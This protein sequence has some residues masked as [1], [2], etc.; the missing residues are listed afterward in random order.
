MKIF[1]NTYILLGAIFLSAA[2]IAQT[3]ELSLEDCFEL[4]NKN[5]KQ[6]VIQLSNQ[7]RSE[8]NY[9]FGKFGF[10]PTISANPNYNISFGRKLDPFTNTFGNNTIYSNSFSLMSQLTLFQSFRYF[11][12]NQFNETALKNTSLDIER[13]QDRNRNVVLEKCIAIWKLELKIEQQK[14]II[15]NTHQFKLRQAELVTEGRI[16]AL[17]TLQTAINGKTQSIELLNLTRD[18]AYE[19]INLNYYL[20]LPLMQETKLKSFRSD[21][22]KELLTPEE[23]YELQNIQNNLVLAEIQ[24][25][26]DKTQY[27]PSLSAFGNVGTGYSTNNKDYTSPSAP[28]IQYNQQIAN[29]MYQSIGFS[30]NIPILNKGE[31]FRRQKL[32]IISQAEQQQ[33]IELK[34]EEI[35]KKRMEIQLQKSALQ[36]SIILQKEILTNK[37]TIYKMSQLLYFE[38]KIRLNELEE[39]ETDYHTFSQMIQDLDLELIKL[40]M[41][42][43]N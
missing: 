27:Y 38:G 14:K 8:I 30:L 43:F 5:E 28:V 18:L 3:H 36:E 17:D 2:S 29:N 39:I 34:K 1:R 15:A 32:Y 25:G 9:K 42:R 33:L 41:I 16:R 40:N 21:S 35:E 6:H 7:E 24:N 19:T 13:S 37:E 31:Y 4:S 22:A 10:L 26:I 23:Y 20:G 12:Q 11:K